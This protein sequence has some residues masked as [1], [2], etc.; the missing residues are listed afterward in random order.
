VNVGTAHVAVLA[1]WGSQARGVGIGAWSA[2][3]CVGRSRRSTPRPGEPARMGKGGSV[4]VKEGLP[5]SKTRR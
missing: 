1:G 4:L 3:G 5:W 2:E